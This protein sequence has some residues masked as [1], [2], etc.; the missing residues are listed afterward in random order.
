[1]TKPFATGFARH[2]Q[3]AKPCVLG[4]PEISKRKSVSGS[5][6]R[7]RPFRPPPGDDGDEYAAA[8]RANRFMREM[9][10]RSGMLL[11]CQEVSGRLHG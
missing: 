2:G 8:A 4:L 11:K 9:V 6:S 10:S 5:V 1:M 7:P 3:R